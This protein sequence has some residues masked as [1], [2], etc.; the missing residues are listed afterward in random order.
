MAVSIWQLR[1]LM[2]ILNISGIPIF[3]Q[4]SLPI[5]T[6]SNSLLSTAGHYK[7]PNES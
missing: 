2:F 7:S 5:A 4:F 1:V 6:Y 3:F